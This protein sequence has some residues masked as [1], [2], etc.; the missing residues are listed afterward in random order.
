MQSVAPVL[1]SAISASLE[2]CVSLVRG[3]NAAA[4]L[5]HAENAPTATTAYPTT[6]ASNTAE[7]STAPGYGRSR[8]PD[9]TAT[10]RRTATP[11][12]YRSE[13]NVLRKR[14]AQEWDE[15]YGKLTDLS[16]FQRENPAAD[17]RRAAQPTGSCDRIVAPLCLA[18]Q[19]C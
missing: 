8:Q 14:E 2:S 9:S 15:H 11:Q 10:T 4:G 5:S 19:A 7:P 16:A 18:D 13:T 1:I 3:A 12:R 6:N 17:P